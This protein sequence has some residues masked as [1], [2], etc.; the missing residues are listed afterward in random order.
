MNML[1]SLLVAAIIGALF[2]ILGGNF[3]AIISVCVYLVTIFCDHKPCYLC[4]AIGAC[5]L[6]SCSIATAIIFACGLY[7]PRTSQRGILDDI[8]KA[9]RA[10]GYAGTN[11]NSIGHLIGAS[12]VLLMCCVGACQCAISKYSADVY[13]YPGDVEDLR[14]GPGRDGVGHVH[15]I[16]EELSTYTDAAQ[17]TRSR[18]DYF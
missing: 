1:H 17:S 5:M 2:S 13:H 7:V 4:V 11:A 8:M 9:Q 3:A 16:H 14:R 6:G 10:A 12:L 18:R 15:G